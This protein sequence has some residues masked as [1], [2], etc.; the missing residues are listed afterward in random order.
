MP[1]HVKPMSTAAYAAGTRAAGPSSHA[2]GG[3]TLP[4]MATRVSSSRF[5]GRETELAELEAALAEASDGKPSLAFVAGESGVGKSRLLDEL[6]SRARGLGAR[7]M[8]GESIELGEDE[9]PYAPLASA[10]RPLVRDSDPVLDSLPDP[11][12]AE[13]SRL[14]PELGASAPTPGD[15]EGA[16]QRRLF[17]ALLALLA[18]LGEEAPVVLWLDDVHWADRSTRAFLGFLAT[19]LCDE[20]LV[21]VI[22]YRSDELHRRHPLR[23]LLAELERGPGVRRLEL[24]RFDRDE[25]ATQLE[26]ILGESAPPDVV[27]R[28]YERSE[29]NALFTEELLAVGLDGRGTLPPT[30]RDA[31]LVRV[32]RLSGG[33]RASLRVLSTAGRADHALLTEVSGLDTVELAE[34]LRE[35]VAAH[36]V[37]VGDEDR[38][39]F[40]HALLREAIYDDLLPGERSD[41][42]QRLAE[43]FERRI[44]SGD[45]GVWIKTGVAHHFHAAGDQPRALR[46]AIV[47]A[48][49]AGS[50]DADGEAAALLDRALELWDRV[51]D[52]EAVAGLGHGQLLRRAGRFHE[53]A[54]D[55]ARAVAMFER[56]LGELDPE[57][58]PER[59]AAALGA[60][61]DAQWSLGLGDRARES[62]R[63]ALELLPADEPTL[64]RAILLMH[65]VRFLLLQGRFEEVKE[66]APGA[67]AAADAAQAPRVRSAVL[68]RLG[69]TLITL[70]E[71]E[72][73]TR[74]LAEAV[75]TAKEAGSG[76]GLAAAYVNWADSLHQR[77]RSREAREIAIRGQSAAPR[78]YFPDRWLSLLRSEIAFALGEWDEAEAQLPQRASMF[79][80][81]SLV[82]ANLRHA[83]AVARSRGHRGRPRRRRRGHRAARGRGGAP[84][85]RRRRRPRGGAGA[86]GGRHRRGPRSCRLGDRQNPVLQ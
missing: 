29:G 32:E 33:A 63:R 49:A 59:T 4:S 48:E 1:P 12:R 40:R 66:A 61:A 72:E 57:R 15:G 35:A 34:G 20:R 69:A 46:A 7:T 50:V 39:E 47:A 21:A 9:L 30:L 18:R 11:L 2:S 8:G 82:N 5:I 41:L 55:D 71:V 45:D 10:L 74:V 44:A 28:L 65:H 16:S 64:E 79:G 19:S 60:L 43:A 85:H 80:G 58:E 84:V 75:E 77:G 76:E 26:D 27:A 24:S 56:A 86:P 51:D 53:R 62:L 6:L 17:E 38:Y 23:P 81:T 3:D 22:A 37:V 78:S 13:L 73:G 36:V 67:L 42:H 83:R 14:V 70:G 54:G 68:H 31:L 52:P 25:L